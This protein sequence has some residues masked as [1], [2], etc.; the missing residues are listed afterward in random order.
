MCL[1]YVILLSRSHV[2]GD[3]DGVWD[4]LREAQI[5]TYRLADTLYAHLGGTLSGPLSHHLSVGA[6]AV[7]LKALM[8]SSALQVLGPS[9][10]GDPLGRRMSYF[11]ASPF[12]N[13]LPFFPF[14]PCSH[15]VF[16][17]PCNPTWRGGARAEHSSVG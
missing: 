13:P 5:Y 6:W 2:P 1:A 4:N 8:E 10:K 11:L 16:F 3:E 7:P 17:V 15:H 12:H 14:P 9:A